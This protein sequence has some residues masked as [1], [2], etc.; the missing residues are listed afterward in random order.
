MDESQN[1]KAYLKQYYEENRDRVLQRCRELYVRNK[2]VIQ[3][4]IQNGSIIEVET[5]KRGRPRIYHDLVVK[6]RE[7]KEKKPKT[8]V[9]EKKRELIKKN[10]DEIQKRADAFKISLQCINADKS[11]ESKID[12]GDQQDVCV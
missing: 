4:M 7:K 6:A 2:K 10:L 5:K 9:I 12:E 8:A 1:R 3:K 11:G